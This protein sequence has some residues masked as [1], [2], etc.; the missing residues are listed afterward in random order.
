MTRHLLLVVDGGATKTSLSLRTTTGD[1]LFEKI[2]TGSNY[3]AIGEDRVC[4]VLTDLLQ[5]AAP[6]CEDPID[7]AV[8]AIAGIDTPKD[9]TVVTAIV[10]KSIVNAGLQIRQLVI[11]NDVEATLLGATE[12]QPGALLIAG[13]GAIAYAFNGT[14]IVRC[15]GWGHRAGDEGSGYWIGQQMLK[16]IFRH[17][18]GRS[19][20]PTQLT[21]L[22][23]Q[24]LGFASVDELLNWLYAPNYTNAQV[25]GLGSLLA[26]AV[27]AQDIVACHIA[28]NAAEELALLAK[29]ILQKIDYTSG[30]YTFYL[31]G[32]VLEYNDCITDAFYQKMRNHYPDIDWR[33]CTDKPIE[34]IVKRAI[35]VL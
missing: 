14:S 3:Q 8:I 25:A 20:Q 30:P 34:Y 17:A 23:L 7:V 15:G 21:A 13:T 1:I 35:A 19:E 22:V 31:N 4:E 9:Q 11:E 12:G 26:E 18:D 10:E 5:A 33:M 2:S 6:Y 29:T 27:A 24:R 32:G 16:V 28:Q